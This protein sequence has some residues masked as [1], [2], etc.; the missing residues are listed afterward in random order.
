MD[1]P[2]IVLATRNAG[3]VRELADGLSAFGLEVLGL[4]AFPE[5]ED[6][7]ETGRS[8][9]ENA[10]LKACAAARHTGCIAVADDSGL[11]ADALDGAPGIYSARYGEMRPL[12]PAL[13]NP[14]LSRDERNNLALLDALAAVP[15]AKRTGRFVCAMSACKPD[16]GHI[17]LRAA[18]EGRIMRV[19]RGVNGFGYDPLFLDLET[20]RTAAELDKEEKNARSHRGG[21]LRKL[22][23]AWPA[24]YAGECQENMARLI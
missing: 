1:A 7:E 3:K 10:L 24:F 8:F 14:A 4:D 15:D 18:W 6:V 21:A 11:E 22:L 17:V 2:K 20:G 13:E 12:P 16:G 9:E 23:A 5:M 19:P